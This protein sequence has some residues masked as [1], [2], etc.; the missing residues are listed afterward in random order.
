MNDDI[1]LDK[2]LLS[3]L[4]FQSIVESK[5]AK[6]ALISIRKFEETTSL[7]NHF[8][9]L[10]RCFTFLDRFLYTHSLMTFHV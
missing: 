4:I 1:I 8:R 3:S 6:I 10:A 5:K 7:L 9:Y 2:Y